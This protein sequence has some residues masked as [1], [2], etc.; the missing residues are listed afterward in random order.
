MEKPD[1]SSPFRQSMYANKKEWNQFLSIFLLAAGIGFTV[2]GIIFFFA[3]NWDTLPKFA[4]LGIV[5][6]I[7]TISVLLTVFTRWNLLTKQIILTGATFLIGTLF[8]VFG[9]IYQT[10]A[11]AYDLFLGW[12]LF[13][14]LWAIAIRFTPLWFTF[15]GL[16]CVTLWLYA[17]QIVPNQILEVALLTNAVTWICALATILTEWMRM[18][19]KLE[20]HNSW[21]IQLLSIATI[22]HAS[23]QMIIAIDDSENMIIFPLISVLLL[24]PVGLWFG[25]KQK[26]LFYLSTIPFAILMILLSLFIFHVHPDS[27]SAKYFWCGLIVITGT[28]SI[29]YTM[30]NLKKKWYGTEE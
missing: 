29:I 21:F 25:W 8:A 7:L 20:T 3:Y 19:G 26:N 14:L 2:A 15:L 23:Y 18:K 30:L 9:Q 10:G 16:F 17:L 1:S 13:T 4:K 5:E 6:V 24:F 22:I 27:S 28:T 12:T 11:D